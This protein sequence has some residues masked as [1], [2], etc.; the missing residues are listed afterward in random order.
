MDIIL[1]FCVCVCACVCVCMCIYA[2]HDLKMLAD[3]YL[4]LIFLEPEARNKSVSCILGLGF[5][6]SDRISFLIS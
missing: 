5:Q 4:N 2:P 3:H 6:R 1:S